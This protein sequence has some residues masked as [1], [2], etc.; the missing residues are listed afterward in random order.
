MALT[1]PK[2][3]L[4]P[5]QIVPTDTSHLNLFGHFSDMDEN[6]KFKVFLPNNTIFLAFIYPLPFC[7]NY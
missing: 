2:S 3:L 1:R 7:L 6:L 5:H 4:Y